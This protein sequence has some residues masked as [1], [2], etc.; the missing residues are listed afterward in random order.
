MINHRDNTKKPLTS[1]SQEPIGNMQ[2]IE[3]QINLPYNQFTQDNFDMENNFS[4]QELPP[5][6]DEQI[7][8]T[9]KMQAQKFSNLT[10]ATV[11][12]TAENLTWRLLENDNEM[13]K[14]LLEEYSQLEGYKKGKYIFKSYDTFNSGKEKT[15][16]SLVN[17]FVFQI[18][19]FSEDYKQFKK[20]FDNYN[21]PN[22]MPKSLILNIL[23]IWMTALSYDKSTQPYNKYFIS[24][25]NIISDIPEISYENEVRKQFQGD[26]KRGKANPRVL[27][28]AYAK[29][30]DI[31]DKKTS[32]YS[33]F[34]LDLWK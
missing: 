23:N 22:N 3:N 32:D 24:L 27:Q 14:Y 31:L 9:K 4:P 28:K 10:M 5:K 2:S 17:Q 12:S 11:F 1:S 18:D 30:V 26:P 20:I 16:P 8:I 7:I 13:K 34:N 33:H 29:V 21:F 6:L 19:N 25:Y 15:I